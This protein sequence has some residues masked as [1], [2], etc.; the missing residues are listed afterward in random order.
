MIYN[1]YWWDCEHHAFFC[2]AN[3]HP[4]CNF[5]IWLVFWNLWC[6]KTIHWFTLWLFNI[7]MQN[8]P[9][10]D[11]QN[12]DLPIKM[13]IF[14]LATLNNQRVHHHFPYCTW[15]NDWFMWLHL[16]IIGYLLGW[17]FLHN[18]HPTYPFEWGLLKI[19]L[20][21]AF[22][23]VLIQHDAPESYPLVI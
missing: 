10:V 21:P 5:S 11:D 23:S 13:V 4:S 9:F 15:S 7:A 8:V 12:D 17:C 3:Q 6:I 2:G 16:S 20:S 19:T 18:F 1:L 14:P 22:C